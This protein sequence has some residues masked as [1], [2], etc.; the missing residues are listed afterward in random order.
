VTP[1]QTADPQRRYPTG[2]IAATAMSV[3]EKRVR[4]DSY[5]SQTAIKEGF[6]LS[7]PLFAGFYTIV[8][9]VF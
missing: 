9:L 7:S 3:A 4:A 1:V 2:G 5:A 8:T 6:E